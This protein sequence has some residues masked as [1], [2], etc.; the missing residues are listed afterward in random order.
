MGTISGFPITTVTNSGALPSA[1]RKW[2]FKEIVGEVANYVYLDAGNSASTNSALIQAALDLGGYVQLVGIGIRELASTV[3]IGDDT[4]LN[5]GGMTLKNAAGTRRAVI[6]NTAFD[7]NLA[8]GSA[9]NVNIAVINGT[10]DSNQTAQSGG[11][12]HDTMTC[13][14]SAVTG[15]KL[16]D[17]TFKVQVGGKYAARMHLCNRV[18]AEDIH[19]DG[20]ASDGLHFQ[21][22]GSVHYINNITGSAGDDL[23]AYTIG[24]FSSY[25][26]NNGYAD[27][28]RVNINN[29]FPDS[30]TLAVVKLAGGFP[31]A[32]QY[33]F[34]SVEINGIFGTCSNT[35]I[36]VVE[37]TASGGNILKTNIRSLVIGGFNCSHGTSLP[38]VAVA[39]NCNV[40]NLTLKDTVCTISANYI[41]VTG[42]IGKLNIANSNLSASASVK[43]ISG[44]GHVD[45]IYLSNS[46]FSGWESV[47]D[48]N[49]A[50][51]VDT[52]VHM[53]GVSVK[54]GGRA[55]TLNNT[56]YLHCAG[57]FHS[58]LT[59]YFVYGFGAGD[60]LHAY[61]AID[62]TDARS[63][64][65]TSSADC[66]CY[67]DIKALI[68]DLNAVSN[69]KCINTSAGITTTPGTGV[70][71]GHYFCDGTNWRN[72]ASQ[73]V[74]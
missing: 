20:V 71:T 73:E 26:L 10:I 16:K 63:L 50:D 46:A 41:A 33:Y 34:N 14:F 65:V 48:K 56:I 30:T 11:T 68:S 53:N 15:L 39:T 17:L 12:A 23:V 24:D 43:C 55:I 8:A 52:H 6:K 9:T 18:H 37:D 64:N 66:Y 58:G 27:F 2:L 57:V 5:L 40:D 32:T 67:G 62:T 22:G 38:T 25:R 21:D 70:K 31:V 72:A 7:T 44:A 19:M 13:N 28:D 69:G 47:Y 51:T 60:I 1:D 36:K 74:Y 29:L 49:S 42:T 59:N 61:G 3:V 54:D 45:V 4:T 35:P